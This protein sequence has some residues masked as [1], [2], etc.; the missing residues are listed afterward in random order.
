MVFHRDM[1][2]DTQS[3]INW[4]AVRQN[5]HHQ[6][7]KNNIKE[8]KTRL[9]REYKIGDQVLLDYENRKLDAPYEAPYDILKINNNGTFVIQKG[10]TELTVNIL[11]L[12][13]FWRRRC[14]DVLPQPVII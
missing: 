1:L 10:R 6:A 9:E 7:I 11:Q 2:L 8:N 4:D 5:R 12:H 3:L 13:P 14:N